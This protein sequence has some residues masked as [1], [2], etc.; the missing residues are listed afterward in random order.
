MFVCLDW[1]LPTHMSRASQSHSSLHASSA[2]SGGYIRGGTI[3]IS[4][5][6]NAAVDGQIS[7]D[8]RGFGP[9][10]GPSA[11]PAYEPTS[12][13]LFAS[14]GGGGGGGDGGRGVLQSNTAPCTNPSG[15]EGDAQGGVA[16]GSAVDP[17]PMGYGS[18]GADG[19]DYLVAAC[20]PSVPG[21]NDG[22]CEGDS[23]PHGRVR[24]GVGGAGGGKIRII[25]DGEIRIGSSGR[26]AA[27]GA[28]GLVGQPANQY[29]G[30][31]GGGG[32]TVVVA[33]ASFHADTEGRIEADGGIG[34]ETYYGGS[35]GGGRLS[36]DVGQPIPDTLELSATGG[37]VSG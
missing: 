3:D 32:G 16:F 29:N 24:P 23:S 2:Q 30:G 1:K 20:P 34:P 26:I 33:A 36:I 6:G 22:Q 27:N 10:Q 8:G 13:Q 15:P 19:F 17:W 4:V 7:A 9:G 35:G 31:G 18:G 11:P 37:P 25:V 28:N 5:E 14:G 12:C 21:G